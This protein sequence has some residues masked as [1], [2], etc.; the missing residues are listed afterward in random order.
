MRTFRTSESSPSRRRLAAS[1]AG[2]GAT[3]AL[4]IFVA[5]RPSLA[6]PEPLQRLGA[7]EHVSAQTR[8]DVR[9]RMTRHANT[10]SNL[11][12]SVVLLDRFTI[13]TLAQRIA[14]E[15]G[16]ERG[17]ATGLDRRSLLLPREVILQ[18]GVLRAAAQQL[19]A[20]ALEGS[21]DGVLADRF[22]SVART[23][24]SCHSAYLQGRIA[25]P[26]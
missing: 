26:Q 2:I 9:A 10:M 17:G 14:E 19:A 25:L 13:R 6:D 16:S 15:E 12:R 1:L 11:V 3:L 18:R 21:D 22:A 5:Q 4:S 20:A 7:P 23:C 8:S 24:V